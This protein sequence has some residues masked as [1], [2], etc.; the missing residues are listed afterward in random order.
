M[1]SPIIPKQIINIR[2]PKEHQ[3][4]GQ[5]EKLQELYINQILPA[6]QDTLRELENSITIKLDEVEIDLGNFVSASSPEQI[7]ELIRQEIQRQLEPARLKPAA[8]AAAHHVE[9][10]GLEVLSQFLV[11]GVL[12]WYYKPEKGFNLSNLLDDFFQKQP[13]ETLRVLQRALASASSRQRFIN[14]FSPREG[15]SWVLRIVQERQLKGSDVLEEWIKLLQQRIFS[16]SLSRRLLEQLL[17]ETVVAPSGDTA[18]ALLARQFLL[19]RNKEPKKV[20]LLLNHLLTIKPHIEAADR[21]LLEVSANAKAAVPAELMLHNE[22]EPTAQELQLEDSR[23]PIMNAGLVLLHSF[24]EPYLLNATGLSAT[25][26]ALPENKVRA[27]QLLHYLCTGQSNTPEYE[28][29]FNKILCGLPLYYPVPP[30]ISI[31]AKIRKETNEL[32]KAIML[33]WSILKTS[34]VA[35]LRAS[36][37]MRKGLLQRVDQGWILQVEKKP[38]DLL[39]QNLSWGIEQISTPF[40]DQTI[41][42][43]W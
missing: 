12:P 33:H 31:T 26:L 25:E 13:Q 20:T 24:L 21:L 3:D 11:Q 1:S 34:S 15:L 29:V 2:F 39:L 9:L 27:V 43:E 40:H 8:T 32:L 7:R 19:L 38:H 41:T 18:I 22:Q 28:L 4:K 23:I 17:K 30:K 14:Y 16:T 36:F 37:L 10:D 35:Q 42:I 6:L 5:A